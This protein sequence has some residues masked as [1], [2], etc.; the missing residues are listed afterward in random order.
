MTKNVTKAI[1]FEIDFIK[2]FRVGVLM[3]PTRPKR[4][5]KKDFG[6]IQL[7]AQETAEW[8]ILQAV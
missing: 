2:T 3:L 7:K 8:K 4:K 5:P 6:C 1:T